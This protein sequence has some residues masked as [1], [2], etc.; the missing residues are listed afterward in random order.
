MPTCSGGASGLSWTIL[1]PG[2]LLNDAGRLRV[3]LAPNGSLPIGAAP[4]R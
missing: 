3:E 1:Q 4:L 2:E